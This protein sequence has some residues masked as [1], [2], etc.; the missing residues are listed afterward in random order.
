MDAKDRE[1]LEIHQKA[2]QGGY[3]NRR[4]GAGLNGIE[5]FLDDDAE[6]EELKRRAAMGSHAALSAWKKRK[7]LDGTEDGMDALAAHEEAQAFMNSYAATHRIDHESEKYNDIASIVRERKKAK[8][9]SA[10]DDDEEDH[11]AANEWDSDED[12]TEARLATAMHDRIKGPSTQDLPTRATQPKRKP[13]HGATYGRN[14][15]PAAA[16]Q[17]DAMDVDTPDQED[18]DDA[19]DD[20]SQSL[21]A[22]LISTRP[23]ARPSTLRSGSS[24]AVDT[25][26]DAE[27]EWGNDANIV[28]APKPA[29]SSAGSQQSGSS[30]F[31][32]TSS[33]FGTTSKGGKKVAS[34]MLLSK[35]AI[36]RRESGFSS[37]SSGSR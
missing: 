17:S 2:I 35:Q 25:L 12:D 9:R 1:D 34:S 10:L 32:V 23:T 5:G 26:E 36:M 18:A 31:K 13:Q 7:L 28:R 15:R 29:A 3:R 11:E 8:K 33:P 6:D 22:R 21:M 20:V 16:S 30:K 19:D 4:R 37:S 27:P 24:M 14:T